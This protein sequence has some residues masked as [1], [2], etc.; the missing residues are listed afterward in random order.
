MDLEFV[1]RLTKAATSKIVLLV[2]DGLG[3]LPGHDGATELEAAPTPNLD[4]LARRGICGLHCPVGVGITPGSGP[5][6]LALFGYDAVQYSV[7]RGVLSALGV[8]F[9]LRPGDV[10]ARGNFC[11]VDAQGRVTDRR[12]GRIPTAT[13][14]ELCELLRGIDLPGIQLFVEPVKEHRF[15]LV[16]RGE[17]LHGELAETDPQA[18]G[19]RPLAAKEL[20]PEA[21][22]TSAAVS[23][24]L[25]EAA[26]VLSDSRPANM[27]LMRG[28]SSL[29]DWPAFPEVYGLR[30]AAAASYPMYRGV[31]KLVGMQPLATPPDVAGTFDTV[32]RHWG[33]FDFFYVHVKPIDSAGEDGDFARKAERI[34]EVDAEVPR[35]LELEPDVMVATGDHSTPAAMAAHGWQPVP[36]ALWSR[37]CRPDGVDSFG[38]G[39]CLAGGLGPRLP[40]TDIMPLAMANAGR[41]EKYGA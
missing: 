11:T 5:A 24:F 3:G 22:A 12:A 23:R 7:G 38:E 6:H 9:D 41:L 28:F 21:R 4:G 1:R 26:K 17:D 19:L 29:P 35:L 31:A 20:V 25:D 37:L 39:A 16:L 8:D 27:V 40:S 33:E 36:V 32:A 13:N 2:M 30:A 34:A 10:A 14:R 18:V 15:L